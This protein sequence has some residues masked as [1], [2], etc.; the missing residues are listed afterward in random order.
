MRGA[1]YRGC[2]GHDPG[3][4]RGRMQGVRERGRMQGVI[5]AGHPYQF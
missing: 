1:K 2:E 4:E 3:G 5:R